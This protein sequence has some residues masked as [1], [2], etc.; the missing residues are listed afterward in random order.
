MVV[1]WTTTSL[2]YNSVE[3]RRLSMG[4][5]VTPPADG[6]VEFI[7]NLVGSLAPILM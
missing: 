3:E 5:S 4:Q 1:R 2:T 7:R 6:D